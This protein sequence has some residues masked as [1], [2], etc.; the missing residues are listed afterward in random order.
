MKKEM[1]ENKWIV[2]V[3]LRGGRELSGGDGK[4]MGK[5]IWEEGREWEV[6]NLGEFGRK[7]TGLGDVGR[8]DAICCQLLPSAGEYSHLRRDEAIPF[9]E[10]W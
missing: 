4:V 3:F 9:A 10:H 8:M 1:E 7:D 2:C 6:K 5:P